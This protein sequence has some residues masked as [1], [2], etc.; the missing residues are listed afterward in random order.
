MSKLKLKLPENLGD[1]LTK[2]EM[3]KVVGGVGSYDGSGSISICSV[4]ATCKNGSGSEHTISITNCHGRC[5]SGLEYVKCEG[6]T[7][8]LI[9]F[10]DGS[11]YP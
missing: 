4:S 6:P 1:V 3:K 10:C 2:D 8:T 11:V 5:S 7:N 9:K